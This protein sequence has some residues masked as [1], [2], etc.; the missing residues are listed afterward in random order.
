M[1][2]IFH[3][4]AVWFSVIWFVVYCSLG[5]WMKFR[6]ISRGHVLIA[7][8]LFSLVF[9]NPWTMGTMAFWAALIFPAPLFLI[10]WVVYFWVL[11]VL[12]DLLVF[13]IFPFWSPLRRLYREWP[14]PAQA[15]LVS[16]LANIAAHIPA[17]IAFVIGI[18]DAMIIP[19]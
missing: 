16:M 5:T 4:G 19:K 18:T 14:N 10:F 2:S 15:I 13:R 6:F 9:V 12:F 8:V 17:F 7:N 1:A 3:E 11:P